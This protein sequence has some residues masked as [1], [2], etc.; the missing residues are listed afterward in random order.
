MSECISAAGR[1][2]MRSDVQC[3][4]VPAPTWLDVLLDHRGD[5]GHGKVIKL[6]GEDGG[7]L[8]GERNRNVEMLVRN[9]KEWH[10]KTRERETAWRRR[11]AARETGSGGDHVS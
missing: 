11:I 6:D 9:R 4:A 7:W 2:V 1:A 3:S 10:E 8:F 5:H